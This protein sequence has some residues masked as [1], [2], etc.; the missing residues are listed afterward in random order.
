MGGL[1]VLLINEP[2]K[3]QILISKGFGTIVKGGSFDVK[4]PALAGYAQAGFICIHHLLSLFRVYR[5]SFLDNK[6][7]S[8]FN[9]P[10]CL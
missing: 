8:T 4:Q 2:H 7:R 6:S 10:I 3:F 1:Q 5:L 9:R